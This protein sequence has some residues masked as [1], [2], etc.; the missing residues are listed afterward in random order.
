MEKER[1]F[2]S[3]SSLPKECS[4]KNIQVCVLVISLIWIIFYS[5]ADYIELNYLDGQHKGIIKPVLNLTISIITLTLYLKERYKNHFPDIIENNITSTSYV[6]L[7]AFALSTL[8]LASGFIDLISAGYIKIALT[9]VLSILYVVFIV[10][11]IFILKTNPEKCVKEQ[12]FFMH[13]SSI[14]LFTFLTYESL[15]I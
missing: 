5:T 11:T 13:A 12:L 14:Y 4:D 15:R 3:Q 1:D 7:M 9:S 8:P 6:A 2:S 10:E